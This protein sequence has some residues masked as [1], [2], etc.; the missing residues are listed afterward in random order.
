MHGYYDRLVARDIYQFD[1]GLAE[2]SLYRTSYSD[3]NLYNQAR[4]TKEYQSDFDHYRYTRQTFL[5]NTNQWIL[6]LPKVT[7]VSADGYHYTD[8]RR[9]DYYASDI[10]PGTALQPKQVYQ[11]G[12]LHYTFSQYHPDGNLKK[13]EFNQ[14][15][16]NTSGNPT[17]LNQYIQYSNYKRGQAGTTTLPRRYSHSATKSLKRTIDNNGWITQT[18]D[19]TGQRVNY[20]YDAMGRLRTINPVNSGI[21]D[22]LITLPVSG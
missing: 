11:H 13:V 6:N 8:T 22:T 16:N 19:F 9:I 4:L 5:H 17:S 18:T 12:L 10:A 21:A 7:K 14:K 1:Q 20:S 2:W 3:F 15:L